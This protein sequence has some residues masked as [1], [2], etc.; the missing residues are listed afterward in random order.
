[1]VRIAMIVEGK[2]DVNAARSLVCKSAAA[3][4]KQ[5]V[6]SDPPIRAGEAKKL[7]RSGELERFLELASLREGVSE[8]IVLLDLDDG[9]PAQFSAEFQ[10]RAKS[11][12]DVHGKRI[13]ICFCVKEFETWFLASIAHLREKLPEYG[14]APGATFPNAAEI[15]GA[16]EALSAVCNLKKYRPMRDQVA[17]VNKLDVK[18]LAKIDRSFRKLLKEVT[19]LTYAQLKTVI[20]ETQ[21]CS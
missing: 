3:F 16:K 8:V 17:F 20:C 7:Q 21:P 18:K 14:I 11:I 10:L 13:R 2:G 4:G 5:V 12:A 19:G 6:V 15:R 1:M 9:C